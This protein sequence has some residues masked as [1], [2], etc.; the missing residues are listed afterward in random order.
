MSYRV[1][2]LCEFIIP[3][4]AKTIEKA[5]SDC[6]SLVNS[7]QSNISKE[8]EE[9]KFDI[10]KQFFRPDIDHV[11]EFTTYRG[12]VRSKDKYGYK[13]RI[14]LGPKKAIMT[15]SYEKTANI[16]IKNN[17]FIDSYN[18]TIHHETS[19]TITTRI[20]AS[21]CYHVYKNKNIRKL[22]PRECFRLMDFPEDFD[23]SVVSDT[24]AYKQA[25]NSIVVA[26]LEKIIN[27]FNPYLA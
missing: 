24:Q 8:S 5:K 25:G 17:C 11:G 10:V 15:I 26:V 22:T 27:N 2:S 7:L 18:K 6:K 14:S 19:S 20:S 16:D 13:L 21:S 3:Y 12:E 1:K 9:N 23:F 4:G